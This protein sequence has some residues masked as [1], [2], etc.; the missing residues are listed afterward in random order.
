MVMKLTHDN[1]GQI[2][3]PEVFFSPRAPEG[4]WKVLLNYYEGEGSTTVTGDLYWA[5]GQ[6]AFKAQAMDSGDKLSGKRTIATFSVKKGKLT[7]LK[8]Y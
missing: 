5:E 3:G 7:N 6:R 1:L 4:D 8:L 2:I